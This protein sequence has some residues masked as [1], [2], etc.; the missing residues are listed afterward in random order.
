MTTEQSI[1]GCKK[2]DRQC[3]A[4]LFKEYADQLYPISLRYTRD[5]NEAQ[6]ILQDAFMKIFKK[7]RSFNGDS[8]N[9]FFL[10]EED[11]N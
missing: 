11:C 2:G 6:D 5:Q 1:K 9:V 3:Q 4:A 8:K 10:D 7:I